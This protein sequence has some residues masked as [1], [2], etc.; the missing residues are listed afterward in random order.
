MS[1]K[2][3]KLRLNQLVIG[4]IIIFS[5]SLLWN[6]TLYS[7]AYE[8][9]SAERIAPSSALSSFDEATLRN[10]QDTVIAQ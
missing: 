6:K 4:M 2:F 9:N 8:D 3:Q 1:N 7:F 10:L 5:L